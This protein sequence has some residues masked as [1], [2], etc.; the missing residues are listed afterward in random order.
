MAITIITLLLTHA[1]QSQSQPQSYDHRH[2]P[3]PPPTEVRVI[4]VR[5]TQHPPPD[6]TTSATSKNRDLFLLA[7]CHLFLRSPL[8]PPGPPLS[9]PLSPP[10]PSSS[11]HHPTYAPIPVLRTFTT[12]SSLSSNSPP[13]LPLHRRPFSIS[14]QCSNPLCSI[15]S[16][17]PQNATFSVSCL[18]PP[19]PPPPTSRSPPSP[20]RSDA[21]GIILLSQ[22]PTPFI[23]RTPSP[24]PTP[25]TWVVVRWVLRTFSVYAVY[26][27]V[28][29]PAIK[30]HH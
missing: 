21:T 29:G 26:R 4:E 28:Y 25:L 11:S 19:P 9:P 22:K 30:K 14:L 15:T 12:L 16:L 20:L 7:N 13:N 3:P 23:I 5:I 24:V 18:P 6:P 2:T 8:S 17:S 27:A 1:S 10:L